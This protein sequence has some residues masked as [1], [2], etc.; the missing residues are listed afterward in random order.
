PHLPDALPICLM[1]L[2][3]QVPLLLGPVGGVPGGEHVRGHVVPAGEG[4]QGGEPLA[5]GDDGGSRIGRGGGHGGSWRVE[6]GAQ[7]ES[8]CEQD[9]SAW[10]GGQALSTAQARW[11]YCGSTCFSPPPAVKY[12]LIAAS[13]RGEISARAIASWAASTSSASK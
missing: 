4:S 10:T 1:V 9:A 12:S 5:H 11:K 2:D 3:V 6:E 7:H 13:Q 8:G